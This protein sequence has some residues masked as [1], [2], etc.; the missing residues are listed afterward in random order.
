MSV[1]EAM[2]LRSG[3]GYAPE[4]MLIM[5][6]EAGRV[7]GVL[8]AKQIAA[9]TQRRLAEQSVGRA[10]CYGS[11]IGLISTSPQLLF[12][13]FSAKVKSAGS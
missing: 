12:K 2:S 9:D 6:E 10:I 7:C 4:K 5:A 11:A 13:V 8:N 1:R 3:A